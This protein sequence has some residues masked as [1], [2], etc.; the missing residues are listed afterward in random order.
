MK[1]QNAYIIT[2]DIF[3]ALLE[4]IYRNFNEIPYEMS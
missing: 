1:K 3:M 2:D 4:I